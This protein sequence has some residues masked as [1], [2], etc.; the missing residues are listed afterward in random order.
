MNKSFQD[1]VL[2]SSGSLDLDRI[3][4]PKFDAFKIESID[5]GIL[6]IFAVWSPPSQFAWTR[7]S[8]FASK[9]EFNFPVYV[10]NTD[11]LTDSFIDN[12]L[13]ERPHGYG[14]TYWVKNGNVIHRLT[15]FSRSDLSIMTEYTRNLY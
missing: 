14:E 9:S 4:F 13:K 7:L 2:A 1:T 5:I 15:R 6:F 8:A 11:E 12:Q 3:I 10:L